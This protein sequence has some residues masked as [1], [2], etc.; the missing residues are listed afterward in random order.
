M[1]GSV[2]PTVVADRERGQERLH[3]AA[4]VRL[5]GLDVPV[6]VVHHQ[7]VGPNPHAEDLSVL[8]QALEQQ[9]PVAFLTQ[10]RE[11]EVPPADH[12]IAGVRELDAQRTGHGRAL[13]VTSRWVCT[14]T[15]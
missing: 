1:P 4:Q 7:A 2:V 6:E 3:E 5:L 13:R 10:N 9:F 14:V 15:P 8:H 11:A 12:V